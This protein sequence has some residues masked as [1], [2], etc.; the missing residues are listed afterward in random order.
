MEM[1]DKGAGA[2]WRTVCR[3]VYVCRNWHS[4]PYL[5]LQ[6]VS[7]TASSCFI[8]RAGQAGQAGQ[9][10]PRGNMYCTREAGLAGSPP[11]SVTWL[12]PH[13]FVRFGRTDRGVM[14]YAHEVEFEFWS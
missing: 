1:D 12:F 4:S 3:V 14:S 11:A 7:R 9:P 5:G 13:P 2:A 6:A 8:G 10:R